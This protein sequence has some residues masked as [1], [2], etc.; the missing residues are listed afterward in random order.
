[1][2][3]DTVRLLEEVDAG[4]KMAIDSMFRLE[5]YQLGGELASMLKHYK[6]KHVELQK[7]T[8][9]ALTKLGRPGKE[10]KAV[11]AAMSLTTM[12]FKMFVRGDSHQAA[13]ILMNGCNMGIQTIA[14]KVNQYTQA[15]KES[16]GL[17]KSLIRAEEDLMCDLKKFL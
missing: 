4:C 8:S 17:A 13:K 12:E 1:M 5:S 15:S 6:D 14:R 9:D 3:E 7:K 2:N 11:A 10:P 16:V